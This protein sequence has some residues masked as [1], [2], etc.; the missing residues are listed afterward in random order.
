VQ[1]ITKT[2]EY[3]D[4]YLKYEG[5]GVGDSRMPIKNPAAN[6]TKI[7]DLNKSVPGKSLT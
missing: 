4:K 2:E 3:T 6:N 1:K 5:I 7:I